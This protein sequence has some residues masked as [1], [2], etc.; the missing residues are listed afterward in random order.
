MTQVLTL[1]LTKQSNY[2][3]LYTFSQFLDLITI[4]YKYVIHPLTNNVTKKHY[5][6]L[7]RIRTNSKIYKVIQR[8]RRRKKCLRAH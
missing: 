2:R 5:Q 3:M 4:R 6:N 8:M 7:S 1:N